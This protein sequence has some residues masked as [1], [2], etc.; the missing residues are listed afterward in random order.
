METC[1][2]CG[3]VAR[4]GAKFC[5]TC[6]TRL[7]G[8]AAAVATPPLPEPSTPAADTATATGTVASQA[9]EQTNDWAWGTPASSSASGDQDTS[10]WAPPPTSAPEPA[11]VADHQAAPATASTSPTDGSAS[12]IGSLTGEKSVEAGDADAASTVSV[13]ASA[14]DPADNEATATTDA[15]ATQSDDWTWSTP[16]RP[17]ANADTATSDGG[18]GAVDTSSALV[19]V[20]SA[21]GRYESSLDDDEGEQ[22]SS[23]AARW[24]SETGTWNETDSTDTDNATHDATATEGIEGAP[25]GLTS[26]D[27]PVADELPTLPDT[28]A[29]EQP[30]AAPGD[31]GF[32]GI[33]GAP[34]GDPEAIDGAAAIA[35]DAGSTADSEASH[36][37]PSSDVLAAAVTST[38]PHDD[39]GATTTSA[40]L[41]ASGPDE[42]VGMDVAAPDASAEPAIAAAPVAGEAT[43]DAGIAPVSDPLS[44]ARSGVAAVGGN[45]RARAAAL[46]DEVRSLLPHLSSGGDNAGANAS[47]I[48]APLQDV[49]RTPVT[50]EALRAIVTEAEANPRDLYA[51]MDLGRH[52]GD[53]LALIDERDRLRAAIDQALAAG[54]ESSQS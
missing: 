8:P 33:E 52:T 41:G 14:T 17:E 30:S 15:A 25:A 38:E 1:P 40:E 22:L 23:W 27:A 51:M 13:S 53:I 35:A 20:P 12:A 3:A 5:T 32:V 45:A 39:P 9:P 50:Y 16:S 4:P 48:L 34:A 28:G 49:E 7:S 29:I 31:T 6:G 19:D 37:E 21:L 36:A 2:N 11:A 18:P 46:L 43:A 10:M 47:A 26:P 42:L 24:N 44:T 54:N